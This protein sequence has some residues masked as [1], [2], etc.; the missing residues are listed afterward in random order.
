MALR[1]S[2]A[3][4][5]CGRPALQFHDDPTASR[6]CWTLPSACGRRSS[7]F[8]PGIAASVLP[9]PTD[10]PVVNV[11]GPDPDRLLVV[12]GGIAVGFGVLSHELGIAGHVAR[13]VSVR[14]GA[15][16]MSTSSPSRT[17]GSTRRPAACRRRTSRPM[18]PSCSSSG[19][20]MRSGEHRARAWR[21]ELAALLQDVE[22]PRGRGHSDGGG[23]S[24]TGAPDQNARQ[25]G[26]VFRRAARPLPRSGVGSRV[27][28]VAGAA[29]VPFRPHP[30]R[31]SATAAAYLRKVGHQVSPAVIDAVQ[32]NH[33]LGEFATAGTRRSVSGGRASPPSSRGKPHPA[34]S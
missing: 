28:A 14:P 16:S 30:N 6:S 27:Q 32:G 21:A 29:Y 20:R 31:R 2:G 11:P 25:P 4:R 22:Q 7:C 34:S 23:G 26:R 5:Q 19:S 13:Q 15:G 33:P 17:S 12:G 10:A 8:A 1:K 9:K 24:P 3:A 18:T